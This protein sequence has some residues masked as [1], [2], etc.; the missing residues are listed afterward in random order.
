VRTH[1]RSEAI[2]EP[3][4]KVWQALGPGV[5]FLEVDT[6]AQEVD[7]TTANERL[8]AVL[9]SLFGAVA[10]LLAGV[11]IYGLLAYVVTERCRE[12]GIRMALGARPVDIGKLIAIQTVAMMGTGMILGLAGALAAGPAIRSLLY[13]IS[14]QDPRSLVFAVLFVALTA[15]VATL[16]PVLRAI[17]TEPSE[18]LRQEN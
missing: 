7:Q 18:T 1:T 16:L 6:L 17:R 4:R 10:A 12:I 8:T 14:P 3:V 13:G 11:G 15:A 9:A 5:P 2:I